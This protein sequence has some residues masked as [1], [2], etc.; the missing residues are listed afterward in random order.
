MNI[1]PLARALVH[2]L[3]RIRQ[4]SDHKI[5][6]F[7][8][9]IRNKRILELGSGKS[10]RGTYPYSSK[11]FF[12]PSNDFVQSDI[13]A[14]YG[15]CIVDATTMDFQDEFDIVLC[16]SVLEHVF[17]YARA[18]AN[19]YCA[20]KPGGMIAVCV[21]FSYPLHD[22]PKDYWR[23]TEHALHKLLADFEEITLSYSGLRRYPTAY[24]A[25]A[26]KPHA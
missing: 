10:E 2:G 7:A 23:F 6:A 1:T 20:L 4:F 26:R 9:G 17:D 13:E 19:I 14:S 24:F 5:R 25:T 15:H 21:P 3:F 8:K 12:D 11:Q 18:L 22:E 16:L